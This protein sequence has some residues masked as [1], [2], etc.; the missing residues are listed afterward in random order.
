MKILGRIIGTAT[1]ITIYIN[2][3]SYLTKSNFNIQDFYTT[4]VNEKFIK[5]KYQETIVFSVTQK[6]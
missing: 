5:S 6:V 2:I 4:V 3:Y 1:I